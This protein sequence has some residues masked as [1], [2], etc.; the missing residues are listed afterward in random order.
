MVQTRGIAPMKADADAARS[1][2][3]IRRSRSPAPSAV[4]IEIGKL[5]RRKI[6]DIKSN[7]RM[8]RIVRLDAEVAQANIR[9]LRSSVAESQ[10]CGISRRPKKN[11]ARM[12]A[13]TEYQNLPG[14][15][16]QRRGNK[17]SPWRDITRSLP[18]RKAHDK[19]VP[20]RRIIRHAVANFVVRRIL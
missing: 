4:D 19:S 8:R 3:E 18:G 17:V 6:V 9:Y 2:A 1:A 14:D 10:T 5:A 13:S 12:L 11:C 20:H 7:F 16:G 15:G